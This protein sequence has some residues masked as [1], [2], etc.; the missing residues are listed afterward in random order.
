MAKIAFLSDLH[1]ETE[2]ETPAP[3]ER[4]KDV[5]ALI[6]LGDVM[7][8]YSCGPSEGPL[9]AVARLANW[10]EGPTFL[11]PGNHEFEGVKIQDELD[12]LRSHAN[13]TNVRVLYNEG[14]VVGTG[15]AAIK[16]L[17]TTLWTNFGLHGKGR[18]VYNYER[19]AKRFGDFKERAGGGR[20]DFRTLAK[21][22]RTATD[23]LAGEL[24]NPGH[25]TLVAT[26][27]APHPKSIAPRWDDSSPFSSWFVNRLPDDFFANA[28]AWVHGHTHDKLDYTVN[29]CRILCNPSGFSQTFILDDLDPTAREIL[30]RQYPNMEK[31]GQLTLHEVPGFRGP[32]VIEV[33]QGGVWDP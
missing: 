28:T 19:C 26:H 5:D 31:N 2:K 9:S 33:G 13:G 12:R 11:V 29:G 27:F 1:W 32:K 7:G 17:G 25:P 15:E 8:R 24:K 22:H 10:W 30:T 18:Q 21:E 16:I 4:L 14:V 20:L 23:W 6:V 3:R